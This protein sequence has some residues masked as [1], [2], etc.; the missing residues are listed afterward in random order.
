MPL[1]LV[2]YLRIGT[3]KCGVDGT[4]PPKQEGPDG[5]GWTTRS[6][7]TWCGRSTV[8]E[9][10]WIKPI[11]EVDCPECRVEYVANKLRKDMIDG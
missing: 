1:V 7:E 3:I 10:T 5:G 2:M 8:N 9:Y 6:N 4:W 11:E